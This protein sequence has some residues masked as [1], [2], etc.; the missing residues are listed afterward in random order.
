MEETFMKHAKTHGGAGGSG[1]GISGI[2]GNYAYQRWIKTK[3]ERSK[4][5]GATL[6]MADMQGD[7][8][9]GAWHKD[10]RLAEIQTSELIVGT[11]P[12]AIKGF[13]NPFAIDDK[14]HLYCISS[15]SHLHVGNDNDIIMA[16]AQGQDDKE[17]FIEERLTTHENLFEP[18]KKKSS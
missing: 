11:T 1:A 14:T 4:Y 3:H 16:E 9:S 17:T 6:S 12:E 5:V 2:T 18:V 8:E 10:L 13:I 15:A 7:S